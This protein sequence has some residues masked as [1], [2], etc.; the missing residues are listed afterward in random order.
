MIDKQVSQDPTKKVEKEKVS[1]NSFN[2]IKIIGKGS[3]AKVVLVRKKSNQ[4]LYAMK[5]IKKQDIKNKKKARNII[6]ERDILVT[7]NCQFIV[8]MDYAFQNEHNLYFLLEYCPG[9]ELF[10]LLSLKR[11]K[12][13]NVKFYAA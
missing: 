4:K 5:I 2:T 8:K 13:E 12:E 3:Y 6:T 10:N 11:L 1:L 7:L 9:G